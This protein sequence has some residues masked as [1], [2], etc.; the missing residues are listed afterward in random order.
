MSKGRALRFRDEAEMRAALQFRGALPAPAAPPA[1]QAK[2]SKYGAIP[3]V[4]D[5]IRFDSKLE[6][7]YYEQLKL[8]QAAG[9]VSFWLRQVPFHLPG[10]VIYRVDFQVH[11]ANGRVEWIDCKGVETKE[12]R[13]K[14]KQVHACY[15][16]R[17]VIVTR[18]DIGA[19]RRAS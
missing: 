5:G 11:L 7:R 14:I 16:V 8:R 17:V 19:I 15:P 1:D 18:R 10:G 3:T 6:A 9:E 4:V 2:R 12:F 13:I